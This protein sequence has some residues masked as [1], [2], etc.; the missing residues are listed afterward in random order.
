M[1]KLISMSGSRLK[2]TY[3]NSQVY[4]SVCDFYQLRLRNKN[5]KKSGMSESDCLAPLQRSKG[6]PIKRY[7]AGDLSS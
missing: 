7:L 5:E 1:R 3:R 4:N 6:K 2:F